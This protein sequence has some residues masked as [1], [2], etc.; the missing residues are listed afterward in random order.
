MGSPNICTD[1]TVGGAREGKKKKK[2]GILIPVRDE[3][4]L[5]KAMKDIAGNP[6]FA[7]KLGKE[8]SLIKEKYKIEK[9]A[10]KWIDVLS[11]I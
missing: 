9:V 1:S 5:V 3:A 6:V 4:A 2:N 7:E 8:A 11:G 10:S